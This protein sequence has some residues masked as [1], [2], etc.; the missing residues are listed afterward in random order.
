MKIH[1]KVFLGFIAG[2]GLTVLILI[3]V[4]IGLSVALKDA[5]LKYKDYQSPK[6]V[7]ENEKAKQRIID[8]QNEL[9]DKSSNA[10]TLKDFIAITKEINEW[11]R[12]ID[13]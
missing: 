7:E 10:K 1:D 6:Q 3:F 9:L 2:L 13:E 5:D 4:I 12:K 8:K 11:K